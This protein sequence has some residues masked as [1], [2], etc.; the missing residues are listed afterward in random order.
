MTKNVVDLGEGSM[1][2]LEEV[3]MSFVW[4]KISVDTCLVH[5][6]YFHYFCLVSVLMTCQLVSVKC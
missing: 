3:L 1:M 6:C 2:C 5:F 4:V